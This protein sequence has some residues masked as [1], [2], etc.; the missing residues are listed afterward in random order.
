[1]KAS[2]KPVMLLPG[3]H[4]ECLKSTSERFRVKWLTEPGFARILTSKQNDLKGAT[5]IPFYTKNCENIYFN[6]T[7][8][9]D[10]TGRL[11][12]DW[13][14][15]IRRRR[16]HWKLLPLFFLTFI[17]LGFFIFPLPVKLDTYI[18]E[19]PIHV[20]GNETAAELK[21]R[22][23][24]ELNALID[25]VERAPDRPFPPPSAITGLRSIDRVI[26]FLFAM[27]TGVYVLIQNVIITVLLLS[28]LSILLPFVILYNYSIDMTA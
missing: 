25:R 9:H 14:F 1:L 21:I 17:S 10:Y 23:E 2:K 5:I 26:N 4:A 18:S 28:T 3:G 19:N 8:W 15:D 27:L 20:T 24:R 6:P 12:S 22:V 7:S 11:V 13:I 16:Q